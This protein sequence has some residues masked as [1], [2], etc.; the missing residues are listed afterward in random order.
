MLD[1]VA[2][3][4]ARDQSASLARSALPGAPVRPDAP[5]ATAVT[6]A[7]PGRVAALRLVVGRGLRGLADRIEPAPAPISVAANGPACR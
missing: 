5:A 2:L 7:V 6:V 4:E 1:F 3:L